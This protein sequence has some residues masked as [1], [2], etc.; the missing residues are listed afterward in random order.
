MKQVVPT[1]SDRKSA[2]ATRLNFKQEKKKKPVRAVG[3]MQKV[4]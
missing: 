1:R 3:E 2:A 4:L